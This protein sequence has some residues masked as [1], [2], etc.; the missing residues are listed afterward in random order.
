MKSVFQKSILAGVRTIDWR[1]SRQ[2]KE[3]SICEVV[4]ASLMTDLMSSMKKKKRNEEWPS[5]FGL[6]KTEN[7]GVIFNH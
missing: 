2:R 1:G 4:L 3:V 5:G 6:K 7:K